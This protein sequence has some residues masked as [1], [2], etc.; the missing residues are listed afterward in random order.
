MQK[1][2]TFLVVTPRVSARPTK[3]GQVSGMTFIAREVNLNK[4]LAEFVSA[5]SKY[6]RTKLPLAGKKKTMESNSVIFFLVSQN[7]VL[8]TTSCQNLV[9]EVLNGLII[10]QTLAG[11]VK[12]SHLSSKNFARNL[13]GSARKSYCYQLEWALSHTSV[14]TFVLRRNHFVRNGTFIT[15]E[16]TSCE[17]SRIQDC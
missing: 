17:S 11:P 12:G 6:L 10:L 16:S 13:T 5:R 15:G 8:V 3:L 1:R 9:R 7:V 4:L 14:F 2:K